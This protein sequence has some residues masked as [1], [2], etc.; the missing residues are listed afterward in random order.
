MESLSLNSRL[1]PGISLISTKYYHE[2]VVSYNV[3][4]SSIYF[5]LNY[6]QSGGN[7]GYVMFRNPRFS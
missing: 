2:N 4:Q 6:A 1:A 5:S 7:D 3:D